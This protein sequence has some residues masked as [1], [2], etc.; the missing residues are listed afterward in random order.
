MIFKCLYGLK[1]KLYV[2]FLFL[3][4]LYCAPAFTFSIEHSCLNQNKQF[5]SRYFSGQ[6]RPEQIKEIED[7]FDCIDNT[8]QL[9]LNHT[10]TGNPNYYTQTELRR[11][12]QYMGAGRAKAEAISKAILNLKTGFIGGSTERLTLSEII[13]CRQI[14]SLL[15]QKMKIIHPTIPIVLNTLNKENTNRQQLIDANETIKTNLINIGQQLSRKI[16]SSHLSLLDKAPENIQTLGFS[17]TNL[18]YWVPSLQLLSQWKNIFLNSPKHIIKSSEW[19]FL[20]DSFGQLMALWLYHK[21]FLEGQAWLGLFMTQHSQYFLSHSLRLVQNAQNRYGGKDISLADID[22]FTRKVWFLPYVSTPVFRLGLRSTFCFL[23]NPLTNN[24]TCTH[25]MSF[26]EENIKISFSDITFTITKEKEIYESNSG[27]KSDQIKKPHLEILRSYMN[28]WINT[29]NQLKRT[30][31]LP[32]MFGFPSRWL[33]RRMGITP[34]RRLLFYQQ[35]QNNQPFLSHLNWQSHLMRLVTVSYTQR[36]SG[37][38]NHDL[39]KTMIREW[40]ALSISLYKDMQWKPFQDLGF[41]VFKHGD[42]LTSHSNGDNRL[43]EEEILELFSLF[44]S[45]LSTVIS[46]LE[47][48]QNCKSTEK[49]YHF[50]TSC[51]WGHLQQLPQE[52]FTGFPRL[53]N[54]LSRNE[55]KKTGYLTKLQSSYNTQEWLSLKDLFEIFL[56][57]HYQENTLEYLDKDSSEDLNVRELEPLLNTFEA[58]IIDAIP[59]IYTKRDAYGF[60]TYLFHFG[61]VPIFSDRNRISAPLRFNN[62]VLKPKEWLQLKADQ[63]DI[64]HTLFL[65]NKN[66]N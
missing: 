14:F 38:V 35:R 52:V 29:E 16:F 43:Q 30:S 41:Q 54:T 45:S 46:S 39:W 13:L 42:F 19:P 57:I 55:D 21:R 34:D 31:Q 1:K 24:S 15:K 47:L 9:F 53:L 4:G 7:F 37:K 27:K 44:M 58:T 63:E 62:W 26:E 40:T 56:F 64:L 12:M 23:L 28:S 32:P 2:G 65:M 33:Q 60:I 3:T 61:E 20:L 10:T 6:I 11:A 49:L 51:V 22:A 48:I 8:I 25:N 59:L 5:I 50:S 36:G 66:L 17:S 18:Q